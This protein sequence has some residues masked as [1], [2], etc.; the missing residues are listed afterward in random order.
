MVFVY[1]KVFLLWKILV[2]I[3]ELF[4]KLFVGKLV[5]FVLYVGVCC[6]SVF[7]VLKGVDNGIFFYYVIFMEFIKD[8]DYEIVVSFV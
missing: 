4:I 5:V 3:I 6:G 8:G 2:D 7:V 1:W